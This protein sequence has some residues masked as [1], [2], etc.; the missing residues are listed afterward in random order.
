MVGGSLDERTRYVFVNESPVRVNSEAR[1]RAWIAPPLPFVQGMT[2]LVVGKAT[3]D[4]DE[5]WR[6]ESPRLT[7][8]QPEPVFGPGWTRYSP[9]TE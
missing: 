1:G 2:I 3:S 6:L 7:E 4:G 9:L 5:L 8:G